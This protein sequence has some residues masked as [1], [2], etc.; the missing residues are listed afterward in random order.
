MRKQS[1]WH[2]R[3]IGMALFACFCLLAC[4]NGGGSG[5]GGDRQLNLELMPAPER[6]TA[7]ATGPATIELSWEQSYDSDMTPAAGYQVLRDDLP[8]TEVEAVNTF[9]DEGLNVD[10]EYCY[11]IAALNADGEPGEPSEPVCATPRHYIQVSGRALTSEAPSVVNLTFTARDQNDAPF[12]D[13]LASAFILM[14]ERAYAMWVVHSEGL[15]QRLGYYTSWDGII[16]RS[17]APDPVN[18]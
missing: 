1:E 6:V 4:N 9:I 7:T 14:D 11:T 15:T 5:G 8:L 16:W 2:G 17:G 12:T 3:W 18:T 13:L 10:Q